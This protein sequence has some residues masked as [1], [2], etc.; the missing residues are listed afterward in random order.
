MSVDDILVD[1]EKDNKRD[2]LENRKTGEFPL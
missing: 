1:V 2:G